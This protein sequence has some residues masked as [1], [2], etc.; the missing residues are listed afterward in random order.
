LSKP[1][2]EKSV[3]EEGDNVLG[4]KFVPMDGEALRSESRL[5]NK[6]KQKIFNSE[7][8]KKLLNRTTT[9]I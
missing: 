8:F 6:T 7:T 1:D 4:V 3:L 5:K 2:L 9:K